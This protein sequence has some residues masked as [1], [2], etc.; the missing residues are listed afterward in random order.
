[1]EVQ[2]SRAADE[3]NSE[4]VPTLV[5]EPHKLA[6][7]KMMPFSFSFRN[8]SGFSKYWGGGV[9]DVS[10]YRGI[11]LVVDE[12]NRRDVVARISSNGG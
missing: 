4:D 11:R 12:D 2:K 1:M 10:K 5:A 3:L 9:L 7:Q 6:C 8:I